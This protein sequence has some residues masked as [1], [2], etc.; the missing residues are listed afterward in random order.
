MTSTPQVPLQLTSD[1]D[2]LTQLEDGL[3]LLIKIMAASI[4]YLTT[5]ASHVTIHPDI[6]ISAKESTRASNQLVEPQEMA[7]AID[8]LVGDLIL[9][10]KQI[11][12][13]IAT[14]PSGLQS[15]QEQRKELS[16][17]DDRIRAANA[18][19][20]STLDDAQQLQTQLNSLLRSVQDQ[21]QRTRLHLHRTLLATTP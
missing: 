6:P 15:E 5:R 11:E 7:A 17:L 14:L 9:K 3:D 20:R 13:I 10:S 2:P 16:A 12:A 18:D 19:F 8:E 21:Q 1:G 4:S